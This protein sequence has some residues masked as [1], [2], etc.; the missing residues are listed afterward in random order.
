[1]KQGA[2][3]QVIIGNSS[4]MAGITEPALYGVTMRLKKPLVASIIGSGIDGLFGGSVG[5]KAYAF[6][7]P[8]LLA[9][10]I[11]ISSQWRPKPGVLERKHLVRLTEQRS[12]G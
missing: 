3:Y 10:P 7:A 8:L 2:Q 6:L 9:L 11:Y 12:D 5:L 1:M 4:A